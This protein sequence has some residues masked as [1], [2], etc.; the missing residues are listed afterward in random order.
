M[1][2]IWGS[3]E[4]RRENFARLVR[5]HEGA[6]LRAGRRL[7]QGNDD[8]A[9]DLVQDSLVRAY[10]A[11][12]EGRYQEESN[13]RAWL[14]RILTNVF[15]NSYRRSQKWDAQV[16]VDTLTASGELAPPALQAAPDDIPGV[17]LLSVTLDE[18][19]EKALNMLSDILRACVILVD[20]EGLEYAEAAKAL[21]VPVGTIRSRLARARMQLHDLL[22][23]F[24]RRRGLISPAPQGGK[25]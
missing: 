8:R 25:P 2:A 3:T 6:L 10:Q 16:D 18:D 14:I 9:M 4:K 5:E 19:L 21:G 22:Q 1:A 24:A 11:F 7:C 13:A 15:I 12:A 17:R 23:D 20:I